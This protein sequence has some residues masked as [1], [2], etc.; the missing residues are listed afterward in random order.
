MSFSCRCKSHVCF[1]A[2]DLACIQLGEGNATS[3]SHRMLYFTSSGLACFPVSSCRSRQ[4]DIL[5]QSAV[6]RTQASASSTAS[7][8]CSP[9]LAGPWQPG[10]PG[11]CL[12]PSLQAGPL[13][14]SGAS[15]KGGQ[16]AAGA[17]LSCSAW[18]FGWDAAEPVV[19]LHSSQLWALRPK[20][21]GIFGW[22]KENQPA[23]AGEGDGY[24]AGP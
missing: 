20:A 5:E 13:Q 18:G 1:E 2:Q 15:R 17:H 10:A 4:W 19:A 23:A 24:T 8:V 6:A 12:L 11:H 14:H 21:A 7:Q 16:P 3:F 9:R 22:K